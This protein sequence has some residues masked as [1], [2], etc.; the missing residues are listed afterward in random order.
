MPVRNA[1]VIA[2][3]G[4]RASALG[5]YGNTWHDTPALDRLASQSLVLD[6]MWCATPTRDGFYRD[7][8]GSA[9]PVGPPYGIDSA[10]ITD[11]PWVAQAADVR[12][13]SEVRH[14][15]MDAAELASTVADT[16]LAQ[17]FTVATDYLATWTDAS[18]NADAGVPP[19]LLWLHTRGFHG[20]WDAPLELRQRLLDADDPPPL[21]FVTPPDLL[22]VEGHDMALLHRAAYGAQVAV[23]DECMEALLAAIAE[24]DVHANTLLMLVGCRGYALGEHGFVGRSC[25]NLYSE[26]LHIPCLVQRPGEEGPPPRSARLTQPRDLHSMLAAWFAM[27]GM[28]ASGTVSEPAHWMLSTDLP[29]DE[30]PALI[31]ATGEDGE[32]AARTHAWMLRQTGVVTASTPSEL[33]VK[34]D[35]RWE[36]NEVADRCGDVAERLLAAASGA[37]D[38]QLAGSLDA[39]LGRPAS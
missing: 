14:L 32:R 16:S 11:D 37:V 21:D 30:G 23:L 28:S 8:W 31:V 36:A 10:L 33:Y 12:G 26:L 15:E 35:D 7:I 3:D 18:A 38:G 25:R 17:L 39:D 20:P 34:P 5:T 19:K 29:G 24:L 4:L 27:D 2:V 13:F 22:A 9:Q 1:I 6:S